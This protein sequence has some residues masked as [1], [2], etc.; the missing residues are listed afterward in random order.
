MTE[1]NLSVNEKSKTRLN[2][3]KKVIWN[4]DGGSVQ[5]WITRT[6]SSHP[7]PQ[8][9]CPVFPTLISFPPFTFSPTSLSLLPSPVN[10]SPPLPCYPFFSSFLFFSLLFSSLLFSFILSSFIL[11]YFPLPLSHLFASLFSFFR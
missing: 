11:F 9:F 1:R 4:E 7:P 2:K 6:I 10:P 8:L 5:Q 3:V